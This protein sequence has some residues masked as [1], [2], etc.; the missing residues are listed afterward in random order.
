LL[1]VFWWLLC[2]AGL[3]VIWWGNLSLPIGRKS[4]KVTYLHRAESPMK[5]HLVLVFLT[6]LVLAMCWLDWRRWSMLD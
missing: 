3:G 6:L 2:L 1:G 5:W 4:G